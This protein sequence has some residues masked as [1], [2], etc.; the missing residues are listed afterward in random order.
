MKE[1]VFGCGDC[2]RPGF[3]RRMLGAPARECVGGSQCAHEMR[4]RAAVREE[5]ARSWVRKRDETVPVH[6]YAPNPHVTRR[7]E[8]PADTTTPLMLA[9]SA[10]NLAT[11]AALA[12][13]D[14]PPLDHRA[15]ST[16]STSSWSDSGSSSSST[17]DSGSSGGS[18]G[19]G[20]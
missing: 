11:A 18:S 17:S 14:P 20:E 1:G 8:T 15:A 16:S 2:H 9:L 13:R 19:G 10:N 6:D 3:V 4:R 5:M 7:D 12:H